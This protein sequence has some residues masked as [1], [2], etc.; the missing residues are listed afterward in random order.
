MAFKTLSSRQKNIIAILS[1]IP[2]T[3]SIEMIDSPLNWGMYVLVFLS[4]LEDSYKTI[5]KRSTSIGFVTAIINFFWIVNGTQQ[6][7]GSGGILLGVSIMLGFCIVFIIYSNIVGILYA[8]LRWHNRGKANWILN[9]LLAGCLFTGLDMAM[10]VIGKG[11]STCMYL[12]YISLVY[13]QYAI[14]PASILGPFIIS[15]IIGLTNFQAAYFIYYRRFRMLFIPIAII[16][17]YLGIGALLLQNY[18]KE[19]NKIKPA[20][21]PFK[22]AILC[23]NILPIYT[24][25]SKNGNQLVSNLFSLN[26][27]AIQQKANLAVWSETVIPWI[28]NHDD[29]FIA[30]LNKEC[31]VAN[32]S[33]ILGINTQ[34]QDNTYYNSMYSFAPGSTILGRYDKREALFLVEK[35]FWGVFLPFFVSGSYKVKEGVSDKPLP[36]R[37]GNAGMLLCNESAIGSLAAKSVLNGAQ[38]LINAGNDGWFS[39]TYI[40]KQHFYYARLRAVETRKDILINN[41]N[42]ISGMIQSDGTIVGKEPSDNSSAVH[43]Y[44]ITPNNIV[45]P[46]SK[47]YYGYMFY[48]CLFL[49]ITIEIL[50]FVYNKRSWNL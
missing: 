1:V 40:P 49:F 39:T 31:T 48:A 24:W 28:Y 22:A 44:T 45:T 37:Y 8:S 35:P 26:Q 43:T 36:T 5:F 7:T 27:Q 30:R 47:N 3:L 13:N 46:N 6:F 23:E 21:K 38:F 42:G 29:D 19:L 20:A 16:A 50:N 33:Y 41:N 18:N 14:Q 4:G 9:S 11:F 2:L 17:I 12:N 15:F 34:Y 25:D 10:S 32:M